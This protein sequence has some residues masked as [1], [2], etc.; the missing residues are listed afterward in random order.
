MSISRVSS[1]Y[2]LAL[3]IRVFKLHSN[4]FS[5][6]STNVRFQDCALNRFPYPLEFSRRHVFVFVVGIAVI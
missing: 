5:A 6:S 4:V 1:E 3:F 2:L